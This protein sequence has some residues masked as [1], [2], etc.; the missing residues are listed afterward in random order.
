MIPCHFLDSSQRKFVGETDP[1]QIDGPIRF[2]RDS[3]RLTLD[4][5]IDNL[6]NGVHRCESENIQSMAVISRIL[7]IG[8]HPTAR[9]RSGRYVS[10]DRGILRRIVIAD[11]IKN[12]HQSDFPFAMS[13]K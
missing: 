7:A 12:Q 5:P 6:L 10:T 9:N 8:S 4:D 11:R 1:D 2:D 13:P 3:I